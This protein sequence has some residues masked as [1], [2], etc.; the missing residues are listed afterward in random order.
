MS[1]PDIRVRLSPEGLN[2]IIHALRQVQRESQAATRKIA[3]EVGLM[4]AALSDLKRLLPA[5]GLAAFVG[6]VISLGKQAVNTAAETGKLQ[7]RVGG[8]IEEISGLTLA[9][10]QNESDQDGLQKALLRTS[11]L[12]GQIKAKST[13]ATDALTAI[14]LDPSSLP[15]ASAPRTLEEI[16]RALARIPNEGERAAAATKIFGKQAGDLLVALDAV[17][18]KGIDAFIAKARQMGVLIDG[19]LS[20]AAAAA[21]DAMT[22]LKITLEGIAT[23]IVSGFVPQVAGAMQD[24]NDAISGGGGDALQG[25]SDKVGF[26]LKFIVFL[27]VQAGRFIGNVFSSL[28]DGLTGLNEAIERTVN[29]DFSGALD[30]LQETGRKI[31][32]NIRGFSEDFADAQERLATPLPPRERP[33]LGGGFDPDAQNERQASTARIA[34]IKARIGAE[35]KLVQEGLKSQ[36]AAAKLNF[37]LNLVSLDTY[38]KQRAEIIK[39]SQA[40]ELRALRLERA[41]V[42]QE[43][44]GKNAPS[45]EAEKIKLRQQ[46]DTL[47]REIQAREVAGARELAE[48]DGERAR[49]LRSLTEEQAALLTKLDE[50]EG[51]RHAAFQRNLDE[52]VRQVRELGIRAGQ[53]AG[54]I[55]AQVKRLTDARTAAFQ[56]EEAQRRGTAAMES[57]DRDAEQIRRDQQAGVI[58]QFE[59]ERRLIALERERLVVLR[60]MA[61]ALLAAAKATN[62]EDAIRQAQ[63]YADSVKQV[64]ESYKSATDRTQQFKVSFAEGFVEGSRRL[65]QMRD[66]IHSLADAFRSL[67]DVILDV[68]SNIAIDLITKQIA[69]AVDGLMGIGGPGGGGFFAALGKIF[70]A[71]SGGQVKGFAGGGRV[72]GPGTRTSDSIPAFV[73]G[74][75]PRLIRLSD[76]E[77]IVNARAMSQPGALSFMEDFNAMRAPVPIRRASGGMVGRMVPSGAEGLE[78]RGGTGGSM[79][80][81][82]QQTIAA[83]TQDI[84]RRTANQA[85]TDAAS[86]VSQ[87]ARRFK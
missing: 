78:A 74:R 42:L 52:E 58:S 53:S 2:E 79:V 65:L 13:E 18:E 19:S 50:L 3:G 6:G 21:K 66:D 60:Q 25:L 34:A 72:R 73:R 5:I 54:A 9:F 26:T 27:F 39:Q 67:G 68:L 44:S 48:L 51:N 49:A 84:G 4:N 29:L 80:L 45:T 14:G 77:Y 86:L 17:G 38:Y 64:E 75:R 36:E 31:A 22:D 85:A 24:F 32:S 37:D 71:R 87:A 1:T 46:L 23:Q 20:Q 82:L 35:L 15:L 55:E 59:G 56:F 83:P 63:Q 16:A 61:D 47:T 43:N 10:R 81:N 70:G 7:Q 41:S 30:R 69:G 8:T 28:V 40:A 11:V 33:R 62:N 12:I 57:F 76:Q